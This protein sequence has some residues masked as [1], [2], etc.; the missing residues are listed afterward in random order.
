MIL[1]TAVVAAAAVVVVSAAAANQDNEDNYPETAVVTEP[2]TKA[3]HTYTSL[4][5]GI[6]YTN[7]LRSGCAWQ[8]GEYGSFSFGGRNLPPKAVSYQLQQKSLPQ[9][10]PLLPQQQEIRMI[11]IIIQRQLLPPNPQLFPHIMFSTSCFV[12]TLSYVDA[13]FWLQD[14]KK[15]LKAVG[16]ISQQPLRRL[17]LLHRQSVSALLL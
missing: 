10:Q 9:P 5:S 15:K 12:F 6:M 8:S 4:Y 14:K 2:V 1:A 7:A 11:S 13:D 17:I 16:F 3:T